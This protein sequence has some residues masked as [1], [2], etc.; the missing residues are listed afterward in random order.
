MN[1]VAI[2][3]LNTVYDSDF[4]Y[5]EKELIEKRVYALLRETYETI[6]DLR[7][8]V[9]V[10]FGNIFIFNAL[11]VY[12]ELSMNGFDKKMYVLEY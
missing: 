8:G 6:I 2:Y 10:V 5:Y 4:K 7:K 12:E 9:K 1:Y 11:E 3:Q